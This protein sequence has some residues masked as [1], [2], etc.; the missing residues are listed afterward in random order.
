M[1]RSLIGLLSLILLNVSFAAAV[2]AP[3]T[4][5]YQG[6]LTDLNGNPVVDGTHSLTVS[7]YVTQTGTTPAWN[8]NFPTTTKNGY[9]NVVL[10][11]GSQSL[12]TIDF[13]QQ[14]WVGVRIDTDSEMTPRQP[15][16]GVPYALRIEVPIGSIIAWHKSL[17]G[18]PALPSNFV[19]CN[20][21]TLN[22]SESP[23]QGE[24]IPNLNGVFTGA[25]I[26]TETGGNTIAAMFIRGGTVSGIG[27]LDKF[28]G[29]IHTLPSVAEGGTITNPGNA[30]VS[31][32]T[33]SNAYTSAWQ[34]TN[35][36]WMNPI[37]D[38]NHGNVRYGAE[39]R[40]INVSMVWI[41]RVK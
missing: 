4:I 16:N 26:I 41:M 1:K 10:G 9:F 12:N 40:P 36:P 15:L 6:R 13:S 3:R 2:L 5:N 17:P 34:I 20:G 24:V 18:T 33:N 32:Y 11:S 28:Q 38:G 22:D 29:H 31:G 8:D 14:F 35:S 39:T 27:Q 25:P 30:F 7:L 37:T 21:Q 19:E 23:Y